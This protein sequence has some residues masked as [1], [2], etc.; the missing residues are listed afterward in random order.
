MCVCLYI[1]IYILLEEV[2]M[3]ISISFLIIFSMA[4]ERPTKQLDFGHFYLIS[5]SRFH[6][7]NRSSVKFLRCYL[8]RLAPLP[9]WMLADPEY[10]R[11][12][13]ESTCCA[14]VHLRVSNS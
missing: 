3:F 9:G 11:I 2:A 13:F 8:F 4:T 5:C 1:Y 14:T 6:Q 7:I 10:I 12:T